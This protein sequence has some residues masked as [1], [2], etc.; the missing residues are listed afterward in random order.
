MTLTV[1]SLVCAALLEVG[2]DAAI[3]HG[4]LQSRWLSLLIGAAALLGYGLVV[5]RD[6]TIDFGRLMGGYIAIFFLVSQAIAM[7]VFGERPSAT[8]LVG[9][10]LVAA[11]GVVFQLGAR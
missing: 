8:V 6:R 11:G 2:G 10:A 5:N 7:A 3:R 4:L 1:L 9:G